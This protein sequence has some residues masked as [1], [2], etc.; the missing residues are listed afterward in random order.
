MLMS[1]LT[2]CRHHKLDR[3]ENYQKSLLSFLIARGLANAAL[4]QKVSVSQFE[5]EALTIATYVK[6]LELFDAV[7]Q[8]LKPKARLK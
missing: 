7:L 2:V 8:K 6:T 5:N 3:K 4:I 1:A